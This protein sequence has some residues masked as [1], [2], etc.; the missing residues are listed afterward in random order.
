MVGTER[1]SRPV[2]QETSPPTPAPSPRE[3]FFGRERRSVPGARTF[4]R[5]ALEDWGVRGRTDDVL[6]CVSELAT[7]ALLHGVP[8]GRG[9][10]LRL[11]PYADGVRVEVHDSG[12]GVPAVP[13]DEP[14][15]S[16]RGLL[17]VAGLADKWGVGERTP[18]KVVWCEFAT[19]SAAPTPPTRS[20]PVPPG[21]T[22]R[23]AGPPTHAS[24]SPARH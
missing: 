16:G 13:Q 9:F 20:S 19:G 23:S 14:D 24:P 21:N 4:A 2:N 5:R 3:R 11:L 15:E 8:P 12:G 6:L 17:L 7:N 22:L 1:H 18:G 10:L